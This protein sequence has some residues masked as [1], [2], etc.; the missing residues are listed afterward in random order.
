MTG[1]TDLQ[2]LLADMRPSMSKTA[3]AFA[4]AGSLRDVPESVTVI[5][6]FN[7]DEG[8]TVI[9][10]LDQLAPTGLTQSGPFAKISL[11]VHS[12][13]TAV[14]LTATIATSLAQKGVSA[15][16]VAG[17]FHDHVFVPWDKRHA[18]LEILNDLGAERA[19]PTA[20]ASSA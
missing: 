9:A 20:F 5:G 4:T 11:A 12:S 15:N 16:I 19:W 1:E 13:L 17:Y 6:C 18:A 8:V 10:A 3:F 2:R 14:G 7:E